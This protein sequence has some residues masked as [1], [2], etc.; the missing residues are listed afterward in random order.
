[1][2]DKHGVEVKIGDKLI[3]IKVHYKHPLHIE[4]ITEIWPGII[5]GVTL[6]KSTDSNIPSCFF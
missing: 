2:T 5:S 3:G 4:K 6:N 1:M